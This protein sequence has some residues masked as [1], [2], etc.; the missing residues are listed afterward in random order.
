MKKRLNNLWQKKD[1][2]VWAFTTFNALVAFIVFELALP[3]YAGIAVFL[4]PE[5]NW[6]SK[7]INM[8]YFND[9]WVDALPLT[10]TVDVP[11][12]QPVSDN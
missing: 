1:F 12:Q 3:Q 7:W 6:L 4:I 8:K 2:R 10:P 5:L 9:V 11:V